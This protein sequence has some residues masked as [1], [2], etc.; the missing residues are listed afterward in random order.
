MQRR[1]VLCW[2]V[3]GGSCCSLSN[4]TAAAAA[5]AGIETATR[6]PLPLL[7]LPKQYRDGSEDAPRFKL[8][9]AKD[10]TKDLVAETSTFVA[11]IAPDGSVRFDDQ[12]RKLSW[13]AAWLPAPVPPGTETLE[14]FLSR[15]LKRLPPP[16]W[17]LKQP[18][19]KQP[20]SV[21]PRMP[22]DRPDPREECDQHPRPCHLGL[23]P[24]PLNATGKF[25]LTDELEFLRGRDPY[26]FEKARFLEETR[27]LRVQ[28]AVK[29]NAENLR[30]QQ[31]KLPDTLRAIACDDSRT[32]EDRTAILEALQA[33]MDR[34]LADGRFAV[35]QIRAFRARWL[36]PRDGG[37]V[38]P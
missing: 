35:E 31:M 1:R 12:P 27:E 5:D 16:R 21:I 36:D 20:N 6:P 38:C 18:E 15:K 22:D 33:E 30:T 29:L 34:D 10:G 28:L 7:S 17:D 32:T 4:T 37:S 3:F 2:C 9:A 25:D 24:Q 14:S 13:K 23:K 11:R 8:K 19:T 26:R